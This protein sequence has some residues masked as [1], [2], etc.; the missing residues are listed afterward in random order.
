[1][2]EGGPGLLARPG[3]GRAEPHGIGRQDMTA[4]AMASG[5]ASVTSRPVRPGE[6]VSRAPPASVVTT[7]TPAICA[8]IRELGRP[9]TFEVSMKR[10]KAAR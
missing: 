6:K 1:M 5:V 3:P 10:S 9:S 4:S 2:T 7:G 8:S